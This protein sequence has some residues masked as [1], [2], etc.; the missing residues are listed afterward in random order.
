MKYLLVITDSGC[1]Q[2]SAGGI[3]CILLQKFTKRAH[4]IAHSISDME[5]NKKL[6]ISTSDCGHQGQMAVCFVFVSDLSV[7]YPSMPV[8]CDF[9]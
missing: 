5:L 4:Y 3:S 1:F 7:T 8:F 2:F 6:I 9:V